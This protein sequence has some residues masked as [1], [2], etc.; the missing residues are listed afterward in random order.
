M[1]CYKK[2]YR[3]AKRRLARLI[4]SYDRCPIDYRKNYKDLALAS[5]DILIIAIIFF[6]FVG[7]FVI[8]TI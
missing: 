8:K 7:W 5:I 2:I 1:K 6:A 4:L 3:K